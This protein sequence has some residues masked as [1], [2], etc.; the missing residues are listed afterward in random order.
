MQL[1]H[2]KKF[3][4]PVI[5]I[6]T[7]VACATKDNTFEPPYNYLAAHINVIGK[8]SNYVVYEYSDVRIDEVAP[9]AAIYCNEQGGKTAELY[10]IGLRQDHRRRATFFCR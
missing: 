2:I 5:A 7:L 10:D 4:L 3:L 8:T 9:I 6:G 1:N